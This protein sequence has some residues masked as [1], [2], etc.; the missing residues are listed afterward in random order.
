MPI[1][2]AGNTDI[3][4]K[5]KTNQDSILISSE[6]GLFMV[7]DGMGGHNG[8]DIASQTA[9]ATLKELKYDEVEY[10]DPADFLSHAIKECNAKIFQK[11]KETPELKGMGTT[12]VCAFFAKDRLY[13]AN[14]GDSRAYLFSENQIFQLTRDHSLVQERVRHGIYNR[15]AARKDPMKNI[16]VRSVGF[17]ESLEIDIFEYKVSPSDTFLLCSDGLY[18]K[19]P[20]D[21]LI[22]SFQE[23]NA[24]HQDTQECL[25]I[26]VED[27]IKK[28]NELGGED[29]ISVI[30]LHATAQ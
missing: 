16:L 21:I 14:V 3:G 18:N 29:N 7:A 17:E 23:Y 6:T 12:V 13:I 11:A 28:S 4:Q 25:N 15:I 5:R 30:M 22:S 24:K 20:D 10:P 19:M 27:F 8:G 1:L 9:V 26:M 2:Y